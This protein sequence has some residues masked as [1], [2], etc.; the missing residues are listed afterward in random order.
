MR[1]NVVRIAA[2][3]VWPIVLTAK[4]IVYGAVDDVP[5]LLFWHATRAQHAT[6]Y[7]VIAF[8]VALTIHAS[9]RIWLIRILGIV[10]FAALAS[11]GGDL[12]VSETQ[13]STWNSAMSWLL[14]GVANLI[15]VLLRL[16]WPSS[17]KGMA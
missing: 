2:R 10:T 7:F 11:I 12:A 8:F 6:F 15:A 14:I 5:H 17:K 9:S 1:N 4:L 3:W 13:A 16:S